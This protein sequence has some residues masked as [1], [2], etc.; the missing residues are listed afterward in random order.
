MNDR[1]HPHDL[2]PEYPGALRYRVLDRRDGLPVANIRG[3][4]RRFATLEGAAR[5]AEARNR[6]TRRPAGARA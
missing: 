6:G 5:Y 4:V 2:G 3:A 1:Y